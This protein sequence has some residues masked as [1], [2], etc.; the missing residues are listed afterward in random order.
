MADGQASRLLE[1]YDP[2]QDTWEQRAK[3]PA[4]VSAYALTAFEGR[5][6]LFGGKNGSQ[7]LSSVYIYDPQTDEWREGS[8]MDVPRAFAGAVVA[9][10]KIHI[11]GGFDG[12]RALTDHLAYFPWRDTN[13]EDAWEEMSALP[14]G[15]Y[16]MGTA[17]LTGII[18]LVGG[19]GEGVELKP[20]QYI[21]KSDQWAS[22]DA[23]V[24][25]VGAYP[26]L[27]ASGSFLYALGGETNGELSAANLTYQAVYTISVPILIE[28]E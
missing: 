11:L 19:I 26:A 20:A 25:P 15:R 23:P 6:Y 12:K 17:H 14:E 24:Q 18:Y 10:G 7:Y 21:V 5:L 27:L 8:P 22:F 16:A 3:L 4:P 2:R 13:H 1:V 28:S 9:G